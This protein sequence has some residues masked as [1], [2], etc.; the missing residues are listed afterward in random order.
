[1]GEERRRDL[2]LFPVGSIPILPFSFLLPHEA[3]A[4]FQTARRRGGWEERWEVIVGKTW[5]IKLNNIASR[6]R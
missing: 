2:T 1:M 3:A 6:G 4:G 5:L